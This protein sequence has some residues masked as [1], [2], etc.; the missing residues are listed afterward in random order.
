MIENCK[1]IESNDKIVLSSEIEEFS[2]FLLNSREYKTVTNFS[3]SSGDKLFYLFFDNMNSYTTLIELDLED[4][5]IFFINNFIKIEKSDIHLIFNI[6]NTADKLNFSLN[7]IYRLFSITNFQTGKRG[8][9][10]Y[11]EIKNFSEK[12]KNEVF[13]KRVQLNEAYIFHNTF[14]DN[15]YDNFL[16]LLPQNLTFSEKSTILRYAFE[17]FKMN[18]TPLDDIIKSINFLSK[19]HIINSIRALRF[20]NYEEAKNS[21]SYFLKRLS[22]DKNIEYSD[23]FESEDYK[24]FIKFNSKRELFEKIEKVY[25][26]LKKD[27]NSSEDLFIHDNLFKK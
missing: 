17:T 26:S 3:C 11:N 2:K 19:E 22:L 4:G 20:P 8:F 9:D 13:N 25:E 15:N 24:F 7:S 12:L 21:F 16:E 1:I 18:Q 5:F 23:T 27:K 14:K 10:Y 6:I